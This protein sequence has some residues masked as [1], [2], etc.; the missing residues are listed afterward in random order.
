I[1]LPEKLAV[2]FVESPDFLV[3]GGGNDHQSA[4]GHQRSAIVV[5]TCEGNALLA[6]FFIF[7]Q[8]DL[9]QV[10]ARIKVDGGECPPGWRTDRVAFM[11]PAVIAGMAERDFLLLRSDGSDFAGSLFE[12]KIGNCLQFFFRNVRK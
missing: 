1:M 12:Q 9:P 10:F 7:S 4:R 6:E 8:R 2:S 11:I 5:G 3:P